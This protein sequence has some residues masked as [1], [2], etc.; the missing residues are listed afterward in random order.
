[1]PDIA[2]KIAPLDLQAADGL[3]WRMEVSACLQGLPD[4]LI[5][6]K[7]TREAYGKFLLAGMRFDPV[8]QSLQEPA[9]LAGFRGPYHHGRFRAHRSAKQQRRPGR[10]PERCSASSAGYSNASSMPRTAG[11]HASAHGRR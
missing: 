10:G 7:H 6:G 2:I 4:Q 8:E 5:V 3:D 1:M 11:A 9:L